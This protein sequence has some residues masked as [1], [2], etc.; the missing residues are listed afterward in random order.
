MT[1]ESSAEQ[2]DLDTQSEAGGPSRRAVLARVAVGTGALW[3][4]PSI[5]SV[6]PA[7]FAAVGSAAPGRTLTIDSRTAGSGGVFVASGITVVSGQAY[8][9]TV[10]GS[11]APGTGPTYGPD[12]EPGTAGD[13]KGYDNGQYEVVDS[14]FNYFAILARVGDGPTF[15]VG[16]G[17][18]FTATASGTLSF[19]YN[20]SLTGFGD[21]SGTFVAT[22][23]P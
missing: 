20:D 1:A 19:A 4:A 5:V 6:G 3:V 17:T 21:N 8:T 23:T 13:S 18:T 7:A 2:D 14:T 15:L 11:A 12:G 10:S 9:I 16:S 22:V